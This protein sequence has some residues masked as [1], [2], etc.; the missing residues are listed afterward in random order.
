[1]FFLLLFKELQ[2]ET[3]KPFRLPLEMPGGQSK[4]MARENKLFLVI[5]WLRCTFSEN[6]A[7]RP[8][9]LS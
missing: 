9:V 4:D 6:K 3:V 8:R 7:V 1:M 2:K 5:V